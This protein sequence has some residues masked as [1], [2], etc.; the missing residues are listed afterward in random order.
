MRIKWVE[1]RVQGCQRKLTWS[2]T[3]RG[4]RWGRAGG[5][6]LV[7]L[8]LVTTAAGC[9]AARPP[10]AA[11]VA[12]KPARF[13]FAEVAKAV[14]LDFRWGHGGK[15]PLTNLESFGH[16]CAFLDYDDDGWLD[17][18]LVG[19]PAAAL[20]R[21][22]PGPGGGRRF[23]D[24]TR[25]LGLLQVRGPW[26]GCAVGDWDDDGDVDLVL[27]GYHALAL[28]RNDG[29]RLLDAT[30]AAGVRHRGWASSAAFAD[31]DGDGDLDLFVGNYVAFGPDSPQ[32]C[33][34]Q[35]GLMVGGCPPRVYPAERG[36]F[37]RNE[38][39][40][41]FTDATAAAGMGDSGGKTLAVGWCDYDDDGDP[42]LYLANDGVAGDLYRNDGG[43]FTNVGVGS[44]TA[45]GVASVAQAGMAVDWA[46]YDHN[47]QF[48]L[49][50]TAFADEAYSL[51]RNRGGLFENVSEEVGV[52]AA[53]LKPLGFGAK[54]VDVDNDG[55]P[56]LAFANGHVYDQAAKVDP[57]SP[58]RQPLLLL[59]NERGRRFPDVS[60][61]AGA[62]FQRPIVG[63]GLAAGDYDNDGRVDLLVVD[64]EGMPLL[65]RNET[66]TDH[67]MLRLRLRGPAGAPNRF[68]YG[69]RVTV[70]WDRERRVA[71]VSPAAS[72]LS[73][74]DPRLYVGLGPQ[75]AA[76]RVWVRWPGGA[77]ERFAA[78]PADQEVTL[79]RGAGLAASRQEGER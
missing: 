42:D 57:A 20:F 31:A 27:T 28:V 56:D 68:A 32:H 15:S 62:A 23:R 18:L 19:E 10:R 59:R 40:G 49:M 67:H 6:W 36:V 7:A 45:F 14:G 53:T 43:R 39:G 75:P 26:K 29:A 55:W 11:E 61:T 13:Q 71:E 5:R 52:A 47:G 38:G 73:S 1:A 65:L 64:D 12:P 66:V 9:G 25:A 21:S 63:R 8:A 41:R 3:G 74:N 77:T 78:V 33:P 70:E 4:E 17:I 72:Y 60:A 16:G 37:Y 46:D 54:W 24:V 35:G 2:A 44:G 50:V 51:Y 22:V 69:A 79:E 76:A 58:Y 34:F 30:R 48:D